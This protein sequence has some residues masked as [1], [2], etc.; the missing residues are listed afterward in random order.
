MFD[1]ALEVGRNLF[2]C[3]IFHNQGSI[4][5]ETEVSF[6]LGQMLGSRDNI[7][8]GCRRGHD[9]CEQSR[10]NH[11]EVSHYSAAIVSLIVLITPS[12]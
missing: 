12:R 7:V 1:L 11:H 9:P 6:G 5:V 4:I 3:G 8:A 2:V 10:D